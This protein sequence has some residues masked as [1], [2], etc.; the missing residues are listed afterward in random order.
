M[1][2]RRTVAA[3]ILAGVAGLLLAAGLSTVAGT[4]SGQ[5]IGLSS[6]PLTAGRALAPPRRRPEP[7]PTPSPTATRTPTAVPTAPAPTGVPTVPPAA[8]TPTVAPTT[9]PA[10]RAPT[11]VPTA[12]PAGGEDGGAGDD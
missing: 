9:P 8:P 11:I 1:T 12:P 6:E 10:A 3:W 5:R 4:L 2:R 7:T